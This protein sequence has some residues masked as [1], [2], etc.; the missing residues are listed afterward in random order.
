[1]LVNNTRS[2][3]DFKKY[4]ELFQE[5]VEYSTFFNQNTKDVLQEKFKETCNII[6]TA[7]ALKANEIEVVE[8]VEFFK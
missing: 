7:I 5:T 8:P 1:M 4:F 3:L 6:E 2:A